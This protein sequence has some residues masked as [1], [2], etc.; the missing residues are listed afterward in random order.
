[1][2]DRSAL[3]QAQS[4]DPEHAEWVLSRPP[5]P[6]NGPPVADWTP[7]HAELVAIKD[8]LGEVVASIAVLAGG[9]YKPPPISRRPV[10]AL[11]KARAAARRSRHES[12]VA[13]V[14]AA[15]ARWAANKTT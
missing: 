9:K 4:D 1:M 12:L 6:D 13:E 8:R 11:D 5:E 2:S 15:Q 3:V 7:D 14:K 10:T